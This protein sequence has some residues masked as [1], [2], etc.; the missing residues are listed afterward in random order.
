MPPKNAPTSPSSGPV[1]VI[2]AAMTPVAS[3]P[4]VPAMPIV[5]A[6]NSN[7]DSALADMLHQPGPEVTGIPFNKMFE[8]PEPTSPPQD[9]SARIPPPVPS[10]SNAVIPA[11]T[12][13]ITPTVMPSDDNGKTSSSLL[14]TSGDGANID[15]I[16]VYARD[17]PAAQVTVNV[18]D[19]QYV[20]PARIASKLAADDANTRSL[21]SRYN[22]LQAQHKNTL[23]AVAAGNTPRG[24]PPTSLQTSPGG[25]GDV[26][27][28]PFAQGHG[29]QQQGT[30]QGTVPLSHEALSAMD[31]LDRQFGGNGEL[32][33][34]ITKVIQSAVDHIRHDYVLPLAHVL[35]THGE[36]LQMVTPLG[37]DHA[38]LAELTAIIN[39]ADPLTPDAQFN[40]ND[41]LS[42]M[43]QYQN[44]MIGQPGGPTNRD[45]AYNH[46]GFKNAAYQYARNQLLMKSGAMTMHQHQQNNQNNQNNSPHSNLQQ[47]THPS[48]AGLEQ[49]IQQLQSQIA[50]MQGRGPGIV[51]PSTTPAQTSPPNN[52]NPTRHVFT[53]DAN[54]RL[55]EI[56]K[57]R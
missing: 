49:T 28:G 5:S 27:Q 3:I 54:T 17:N 40:P 11:I 26:Q 57:G 7:P 33:T 22:Q 39:N 16:H 12:P 52:P 21:Q 34:A 14:F 42:L 36:Q 41:V 31:V 43:R 10:H 45:E 35:G 46:S 6:A 55:M 2:P 44:G 1:A 13:G 47:G 29:Q 25:V 23:D 8:R 9:T 50:Q 38:D 53:P 56:I 19:Q 37:H 30:I 48:V 20:L 24:T 4:V 18:G 32:K 51:I 15:R